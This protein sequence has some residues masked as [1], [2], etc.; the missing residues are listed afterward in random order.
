MVGRDAVSPDGNVPDGIS[1]MGRSLPVTRGQ[2]MTTST[3][4]AWIGPRTGS[5]VVGGVRWRRRL[6]VDH[7]LAQPQGFDLMTGFA[8]AGEQP[9][10][11]IG[12]AGIIIGQVGVDRRAAK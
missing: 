1:L 7:L 9:V 10:A 6:Q 12:K 3:G 11:V 5:K 8:E 4:P 2:A